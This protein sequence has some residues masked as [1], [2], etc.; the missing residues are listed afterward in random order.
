[1]ERRSGGGSKFARHYNA[2][3]AQAPWSVEFTSEYGSLGSDR[4][5]AGGIKNLLGLCWVI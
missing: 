4:I 1:M 3:G 2:D 5:L